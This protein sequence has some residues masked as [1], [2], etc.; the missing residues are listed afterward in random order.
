MRVT[1]RA[2]ATSATADEATGGTPGTGLVAPRLLACD[3]ATVAQLETFTVAA[4]PARTSWELPGWWCV[5]DDGGY[6]GRAN[7]ATAMPAGDEAQAPLRDVAASYR[8]R[9]LAPKIRWTPLAPAGLAQEAAQAGWVSA[10]EVVVLLS[11]CQGDTA[12]PRN[13]S[14]NSTT[15]SLLD[16]PD[17]GWAGVYLDANADGSGPA[18]LRLA[19]AA[20]EQRQFVK[21]EVDGATAA[22][23]LGVVIGNVLGIFDVVTAPEFR[24]RGLGRQVVNT[25]K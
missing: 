11:A 2:V 19:A 1:G 8:Q 5:A 22:I 10:G 20:P 24:R 12:E 14:V 9:A 25:L 21:V 18:R 13:A 4:I 15:T 6:V 16:A 23:G 3:L 17:T 7:S